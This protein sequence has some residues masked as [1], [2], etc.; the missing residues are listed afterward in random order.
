M[1]P[2]EIRSLVQQ[3]ADAWVSGN[4]EAF[5]ALFTSDGEFIVPGDRWVGQAAIQQ[6]AADFA[7]AYS[8]VKIDIRR[9]IVEDDQAVVEWDWQETEKATGQHGSADDVIVIDFRDGRF[10]R[11]REYIDTQSCMKPATQPLNP[12]LL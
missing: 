9:I 12:E 7:S 4:A 10:S 3:A 5:A 2:E 6:V 1:Q 11:W 8:N